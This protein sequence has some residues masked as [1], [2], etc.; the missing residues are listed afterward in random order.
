MRWF[1]MGAALAAGGLSAA[2]QGRSAPWNVYASVPMADPAYIAKGEAVRMRLARCGL[3]VISDETRNF[4]G[5]AP[6]LFVVL[7][8]PHRGADEARA[9]LDKAKAC[10]VTG[11]TRQTRRLF[12]D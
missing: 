1:I 4:A 6:D 10:G 2:A 11:Y 7:S 5:L 8:G 12:G 3:S 9:A